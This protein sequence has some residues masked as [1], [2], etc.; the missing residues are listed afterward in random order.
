MKIYLNA[1]VEIYEG[2]VRCEVVAL[3]MAL[4]APTI[5]PKDSTLILPG[6]HTWVVTE[7][8]VFRWDSP[9]ECVVSVPVFSPDMENE[10]DRRLGENMVG[11]MTASGW[12]VAGREKYP[13]GRDA[14]VKDQSHE[15]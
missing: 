11:V 13:T 6:D 15:G 3:E 12:V 8:H 2:Q 14:Q 1:E 10:L 5:P 7:T 4:E 9:I